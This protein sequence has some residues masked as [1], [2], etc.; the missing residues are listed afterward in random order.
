MLFTENIETIIEACLATPYLTD[1][2]DSRPVNLMLSTESGGGKSSLLLTKYGSVKGVKSF[3]DVTYDK[4]AKKHLERVYEGKEKTW[5]FAE[6]NKIL[7]RKAS[8]ASNTVGLLDMAC[9]EGVAGIELP[10]FEREWK[11]YPKVSVIIGL[12]PSF[13]YAHSV[14]WWGFGFLQRFVLVTW[15]YTKPQINLILWRIKN[16]RHLKT[17]IWS[18]TFEATEVKLDSKYSDYIETKL[19]KPIIESNNRFMTEM[20]K[21]SNET[22]D[23]KTESELPFRT[24]MRLQK[25]LKGLALRNGHTKVTNEDWKLFKKCFP[26]LNP[27]FNFV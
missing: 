5:I 10:Y 20:Y 23:P 15:R 8:V 7:S 25:L 19:T 26:H 13:L 17:G 1:E 16:Q 18:H 2:Q 9:E 3:G 21:R 27:D 11:P 22:F 4:L 24:Q 12:T 14:N 6:F